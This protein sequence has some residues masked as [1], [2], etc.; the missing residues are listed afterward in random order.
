MSSA[1][2]GDNGGEKLS[3][4]AD[5]KIK[6]IFCTQFSSW[7]ILSKSESWTKKYVGSFFVLKLALM[8]T[9]SLISGRALWSFGI[10]HG[11]QFA[12][13]IFGMMTTELQSFV[14]N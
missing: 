10:T 1:R 8:E 5:K 13:I 11:H 6:G 9:T 14:K 7:I 2:I 4:Y 3:K 12:G